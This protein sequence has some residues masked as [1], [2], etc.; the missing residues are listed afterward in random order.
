MLNSGEPA[1]V[2]S[3]YSI[4]NNV[5]HLKQ[6]RSILQ[7]LTIVRKKIF[8]KNECLT[9][10]SAETKERKLLIAIQAEHNEGIW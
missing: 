6:S 10:Y 8:Q 3:N 2:K 5:E 9:L 7:G 1:F 4:F